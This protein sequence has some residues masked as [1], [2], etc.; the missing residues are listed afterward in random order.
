[1]S[2]TKTKGQRVNHP[3]LNINFWL[4]PANQF[5]NKDIYSKQSKDYFNQLLVDKVAEFSRSHTMMD[6]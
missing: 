5:W 6:K 1:M 4:E 2:K 3:Y